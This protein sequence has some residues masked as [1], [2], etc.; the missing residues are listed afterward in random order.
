MATPLKIVLSG[1]GG[2]GGTYVHRLL[3]Q[4]QPDAFALVGVVD[5]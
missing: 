3:D 4:P 2:Y 5:P 1:I